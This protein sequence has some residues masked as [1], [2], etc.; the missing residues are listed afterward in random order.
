MTCELDNSTKLLFPLALCAA[1]LGCGSGP[2]AYQGNAIAVSSDSKLAT[3]WTVAQ[4]D[5]ATN[6]ILLNAAHT[7]VY[8]NEAPDWA[9]AQPAAENMSSDGVIVTPVN[10]PYLWDQ[11]VECYAYTDG[12]S[13]YV[14]SSMLYSQGA[15]GYE[16][17]NVILEKLGYDISKR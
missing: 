2:N 5:L 15:T 9:Q 16:M 1:L 12:T 3:M 7:G 10:R 4:N 17:E 13:I 8:G 14:I 11:N 6:P